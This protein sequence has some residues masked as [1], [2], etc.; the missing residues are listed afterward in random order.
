MYNSDVNPGITNVFSTAA[1]R[2]G[3]SEI[4]EYTK[5]LQQFNPED[6]Q[7]CN[8]VTLTDVPSNCVRFREVSVTTAVDN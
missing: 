2:F 8:V 4:N 3:H 7:D 1:Y 5:F 6:D